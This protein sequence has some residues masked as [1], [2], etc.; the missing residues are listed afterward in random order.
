M[1]GK[2]MALLQGTRNMQQLQSQ[3]LS[4]QC[5]VCSKAPAPTGA[6]QDLCAQ[7]D[8]DLQGARE[9][10][11]Q[12]ATGTAHTSSPSTLIIIA[13][14]RPLPNAVEM[15]VSESDGHALAEFLSVACNEEGWRRP[16]RPQPDAR[17]RAGEWFMQDSS[18]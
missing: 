13:G 5:Q 17:Y 1:A 10:L 16:C 8:G 6:N 12:I 18:Q 4:A 11:L 2:L 14:S 15:Q 3:H 7:Y 9:R